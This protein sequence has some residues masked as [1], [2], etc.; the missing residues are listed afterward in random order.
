VA[1]EAQRQAD[2]AGIPEAALRPE[3]P[4]G[5]RTGAGERAATQQK[6][7]SFQEQEKIRRANS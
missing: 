5:K 2:A 1:R 3:A 4:G 6:V 7:P